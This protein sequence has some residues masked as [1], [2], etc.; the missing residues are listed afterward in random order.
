MRLI[1]GG[2]TQVSDFIPFS[3]V[4]SNGCFVEALTLV[5]ELSNVITSVLQQVILNEELDPLK[6]TEP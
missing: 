2:G 3:E 1:E 4:I 5:E 6:D